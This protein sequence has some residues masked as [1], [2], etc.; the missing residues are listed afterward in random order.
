MEIIYP[1]ITGVGATTPLG[2][3]INKNLTAIKGSITAV[4]KYDENDY[5]GNVILDKNIEIPTHLSG[6]FK[7]INRGGLLGHISGIEAMSMV[8]YQSIPQEDRGLFLATGDLTNTGCEFLYQTTKNYLNTPISHIPFER[9]NKTALNKVNP[10]FLLDSIA[11]NPF[12][13]ISAYF[14]IMG[15]NTSIASLSPCGSLALDLAVRSIRQ[16]RSKLSLVIGSTSWINDLT[17]FELKGLGL[18]SRCKRGAESYMP[19]DKKRDGFIPSEGSSALVLEHPDTALNNKSKV[20]G[21]VINTSSICDSTDQMSISVPAEITYKAMKTCIKE[22]GIELKDIAFICAHGSGSK[23]GD[24]SEMVSLMKL[25]DDYCKSIPVCAI[26]PYT[27]HMGAGSD[28]F[29]IAI[30]IYCL[31][32][33]FIPKTPNL[34]EPE[35]RFSSIPFTK[36]NIE[37]QKDIFMTVSNGLGGQCVASIIQVLKD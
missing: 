18:M 16:N 10:F 31:R 4:T 34:E 28:I 24:L 11:N 29:D 8:M 37:T 15:D 36:T 7:F 6:Q 27:G 2:V 25:F 1:V 35:E 21:R 5:R 13:F 12:S 30:C 22:A 17:I 26:K 9:F 20:L 23:R 3:G 32:D 19:F 14:D 33:G